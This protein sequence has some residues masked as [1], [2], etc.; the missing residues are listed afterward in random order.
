MKCFIS[1]Q[2]Y[3]LL[4]VDGGYVIYDIFSEFNFENV[5]TLNKSELW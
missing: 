2:G 3:P 4:I 1:Y 5:I